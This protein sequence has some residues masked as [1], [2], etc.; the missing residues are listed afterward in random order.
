MIAQ[1][2][3]LTSWFKVFFGNTVTY[4]LCLKQKLVLCKLGCWFWNYLLFFF[5]W[6]N[7]C[8]FL[9]RFIF[10]RTERGTRVSSMNQI[11][12]NY[13][14]WRTQDFQ[15]DECLELDSDLSPCR[16][17]LCRISEWKSS[18]KRL[19]YY[20]F[21]LFPKQFGLILKIKVEVLIEG[22]ASSSLIQ[23]ILPWVFLFQNTQC[24]LSLLV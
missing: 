11:A 23:L 6:V 24:G 20:F 4:F 17:I 5:Y 19:L 13:F 18:Q 21:F 15:T 14:T 3:C 7:C 9:D 16:G 2:L 1:Q 22:A 8:W 10:S 12:W